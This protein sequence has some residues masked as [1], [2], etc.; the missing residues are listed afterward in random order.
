MSFTN[1]TRLAIALLSCLFLLACAAKHEYR[2]QPIRSVDSYF[3]HLEIHDVFLAAEAIYDDKLLEERFGYNL[4]K[5]GVIPVNLL[6]DNRGE[7]V[8]LILPG[9]TLT[10]AK[11]QSWD[12]LPQNV[13]VNRIGD[14]TSGVTAEQGLGRTA[15]GALVGAILGAAIGVAT[16]TSVGEAAGKGAAVGGA[17]GVGSA[18]LGAGGEDSTAEVARDYSSLALNHSAVEPGENT[19]G[20]LYFPAEADRPTRLNLKVK[21][22]EGKT[23]TIGLPL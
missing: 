14:Y 3:N 21:I 2:A 1:R 10:D 15:K 13:V 23:Q 5:A 11:G 4:K 22:G 20:L 8:T 7:E 18:V 19:H 12:I 16:G 17:I 6:V 9:V